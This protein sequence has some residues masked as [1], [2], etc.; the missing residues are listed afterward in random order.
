MEN[1][2]G[3]DSSLHEDFLPMNPDPSKH[4]EI[5]LS[6]NNRWKLLEV[7]LKGRGDPALWVCRIDLVSQCVHQSLRDDVVVESNTDGASYR[8]GTL[9]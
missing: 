5:G 4:H 9:T 6:E 3:K 1:Q 7:C 8:A 2:L